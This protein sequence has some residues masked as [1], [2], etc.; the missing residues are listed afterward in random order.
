LKKILSKIKNNFYIDILL[1]VFL[2]HIFYK[3]TFIESLQGDFYL[4]GQI[5]NGDVTSKSFFVESPTY[6]L[7]G[8]LF[9][10]EDFDIYRLVIYLITL[11]CFIMIVFNLQFLEKYSTLFF[12]SG[13]L[14]TSS[15]FVGYVD[16]ISVLIISIVSKNLLQSNFHLLKISFYLLL[17]SINHNAISFVICI[18]FL[19]L[20]KNQT[21]KK[22]LPAIFI[23]QILGNL[24]VQY[25]LKFIGFEGRGRLRFVFNENVIQNSVTF[26]S[27]N[28]V[29]VL[30]SGFLGTSVLMLLIAN[31]L[32]WSETR[33]IFI[34]ILIA[35]FFT[36]IALDTSRIFSLL[37]T[38]IIIFTLYKY[39]NLV[40][41]K[42]KLGVIYTSSIFLHF[43]VGVYYF[44]GSILK[45]SPM[46][47]SENFYNFISRIVN[48]LMSNIWN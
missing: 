46:S 33:N 4:L 18:I 10:I 19:I 17:L 38:P 34:S 2:S 42:N 36:S 16:V 6:T 21:K 20:V 14:L 15:W 23:S 27:E 41:F 40:N 45:Q 28:L 44:Y 25:Y 7:F 8:L 47:N 12:L 3:I 31:T 22:L 48:S 24:L 29:I 32:S 35:L 43:L 37:V 9:D 39:K 1:V 30:W 26:I 5:R 11:V 13:W